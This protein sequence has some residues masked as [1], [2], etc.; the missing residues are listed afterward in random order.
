ME[1]YLTI[2]QTE[3]HLKAYNVPYNCFIQIAEK[4]SIPAFCKNGIL[5]IH[6]VMLDESLLDFS[7][8]L[9]LMKEY[10]VKIIKLNGCYTDNKNDRNKKR[11]IKRVNSNIFTVLPESIDDYLSQLGNHTRRDIR[12]YE[13]KFFK[14]YNSVELFTQYNHGVNKDD[15]MEI[16][17]LNWERCISKGFISGIDNLEAEN[18]FEVIKLYGV[19]TIMKLDNKVIAGTIGTILG[20]EMTLHVISHDN[21]YNDFNI[22]TIMIKKTVEQA[23]N[24]KIHVLNFT[25]GGTEIVDKSG[26]ANWKLQFGSERKFLNDVTYFKSF[27]DYYYAKFTDK[28]RVLRKIIS[29]LIIKLLKKIYHFA[30]SKVKVR[31]LK[32]LKHTSLLVCVN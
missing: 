8:I 22:G 6:M 3:A 13:R 28:Y 16:I 25:W 1:N 24:D 5:S 15:Y 26:K 21:S 11:L 27:T 30:R 32:Y 31:I 19:I 14:T 4:P 7:K 9:E 29:D 17:R 23:I 18:L 20:D 12:S 10:R 2:H